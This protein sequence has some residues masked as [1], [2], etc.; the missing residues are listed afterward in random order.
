VVSRHTR[1]EARAFLGVLRLGIARFVDCG[2][3][4]QSNAPSLHTRTALFDRSSLSKFSI[5]THRPLGTFLYGDLTI[6]F[7]QLLCHCRVCLDLLFLIASIRWGEGG[8]GG[9]GQLQHKNVSARGLCSLD[10]R[11]DDASMHHPALDHAQTQ[12]ESVKHK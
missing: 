8:S 10:L 5:T 12:A 7:S 9:G 4:R 2:A 11:D 3:P 1:D 6:A